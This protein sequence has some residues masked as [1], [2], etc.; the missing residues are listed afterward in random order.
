MIVFATW[1]MAE[2]EIHLGPFPIPFLKLS[3]LKLIRRH[4][5]VTHPK[6][7]FYLLYCVFIFSDYS[8]ILAKESS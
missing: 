7:V 2:C 1:I 4:S 6:P 8:K 3:Q 5:Y